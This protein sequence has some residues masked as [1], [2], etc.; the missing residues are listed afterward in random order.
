MSRRPGPP[1]GNNPNVR[2]TPGDRAVVEEFRAYLAARSRPCPG[3][4][5]RGHK[6]MVC[7]APG[8]VDECGCEGRTDDA[9]G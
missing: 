1:C 8:D 3:C 9:Q 2:L 7:R 6:G 5:H 4:G